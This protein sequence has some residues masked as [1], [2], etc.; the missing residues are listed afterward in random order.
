MQRAGHQVSYKAV[1]RALA[2]ARLSVQPAEAHGWL[3]GALCGRK[4]LSMEDWFQELLEA[5]RIDAP[6][7]EFQELQA[8]PD[9][10]SNDA[11]RRLYDRTLEALQNGEMQ[12]VPLLPDDDSPLER[13]TE[14]L[15]L[16]CEGF[17]YGLGTHSFL[18]QEALSAEVREI[19]GD[20]AEIGRAEATAADP[21]QGEAEE[22]A[23]TEVLE[24]VRVSVQLLHDDLSRELNS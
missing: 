18:S 6:T 11:L 23:Y 8:T 19:I 22:E 2:V 16:W 3:C 24:F 21:E 15:A 4:V 10:G 5:D 12:F 1:G 20:L 17:L 14:S 9:G 7:D 13:R